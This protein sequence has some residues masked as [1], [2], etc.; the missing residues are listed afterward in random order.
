MKSF[1]YIS[2]DLHILFYTLGCHSILCSFVVQIVP[3]LAMGSF[4]RLPSARVF[5]DYLIFFVPTNYFPRV[6]G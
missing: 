4:R 2:M 6:E 5:T 1:I 3:H